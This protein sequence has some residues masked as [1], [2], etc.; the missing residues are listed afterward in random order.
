MFLELGWLTL[1]AG[2]NNF[3]KNIVKILKKC[4]IFPL[5]NVCFWH[6]FQIMSKFGNHFFNIVM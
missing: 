5:N 4:L 3:T 6:I 2:H 1:G